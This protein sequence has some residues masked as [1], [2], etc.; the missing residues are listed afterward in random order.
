MSIDYSTIRSLRGPMPLYYQYPENWEP[1]PAYLEL[2]GSRLIAGWIKEPAYSGYTDVLKLQGAVRW[3]VRPDAS[4]LSHRL[5]VSF[6]I[7][8]AVS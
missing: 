2:C 6:S 4:R 7:S 8:P 5:H 3:G 1:Q